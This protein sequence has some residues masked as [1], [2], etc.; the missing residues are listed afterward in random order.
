MRITHLIAGATTATMLA[1]CSATT[2]AGDYT[3]P[4]TPTTS[5]RPSTVTVLVHDS[6]ALPDD[7]IADFEASSGIDLEFT[8]LDGAGTLVNHIILTAGSPTGDVVYGID[9]TFASRAIEADVFEQYVAPS[10]N[11]EDTAGG[12]LTAIDFSDVCFNVALDQIGSDAPQ[13]FDDLIAPGIPSLVSVPN[14]TQSSPGLAF[15]LATYAVYGDGWRDYWMALRDGGVN[16]AASWSDAYFV[17][18]AAPQ[19]GGD[20][21][22]VLS[23]ASSPPSEVINGEPTTA[24]LLDTCFRQVEYAGVLKGAHNP[25]ASRQVVEWLLSDE[26]QSSVPE[27]MYVYPI[28]DTAT[29]PAEWVKHAPLAENPVMLPIEVIGAE[30]ERLLREWS[31]LMRG[32]M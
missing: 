31:E 14:P 20:F 10:A 6:F 5:P 1:A 15:L 22:I 24:A 30:R 18:F 25:Q 27:S 2:T 3:P 9:N 8:M 32:H 11:P 23:Y 17:D 16:I 29:L 13:T 28:S 19:Y 7:V 12:V 26:V 21:P 4:G